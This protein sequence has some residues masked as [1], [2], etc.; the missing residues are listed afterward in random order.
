MQTHKNASLRAGPA[1]FKAP[2]QLPGSPKT[3]PKPVTAKQP[4]FTKE[5]KKWLVVS[6][7][8]TTFITVFAIRLLM[9]FPYISCSQNTSTE[10]ANN[11]EL[12]Y[13]VTPVLF[14][15]LLKILMFKMTFLFDL[16]L[17]FSSTCCS[18][19]TSTESANKSR[20]TVLFSQPE[21]FTIFS[22]DLAV[23]NDIPI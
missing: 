13:S 17:L 1:P 6:R 11:I 14:P 10:S 4:V 23:Q 21:I 2:Q 9:L 16:C 19:D 5:G 20:E 18:Q 3:A 15:Y 7:R 12:I 22:K 8:K